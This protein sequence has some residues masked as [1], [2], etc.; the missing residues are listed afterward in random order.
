[1]FDYIELALDKSWGKDVLYAQG[2]DGSHDV[3]P[4]KDLEEWCDEND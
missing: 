3:V 1:M 4:L 2:E